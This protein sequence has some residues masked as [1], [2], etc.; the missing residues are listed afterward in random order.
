MKQYNIHKKNDDLHTK[1]W[2]VLIM[3]MYNC[4]KVDFTGLD[5]AKLVNFPKIPKLCHLGMS[6]MSLNTK[7][8]K[9]W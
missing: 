1:R 3:C 6:Q 9:Y 7:F 8:E 5:R 4:L 2:S